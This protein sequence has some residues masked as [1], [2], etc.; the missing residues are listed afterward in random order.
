MNYLGNPQNSFKVFH[1]A[2]TNGKGSVC[3]YINNILLANGKNVGLFTS[4]HL[5][6]INER[7]RINNELI[8]D[9]EFASICLT[10]KNAVDDLVKKG[11]PHP[12]FFEFVFAMCCV[13]FKKK[14]VEYAVIETGLGGRLD[15]TNI[16]QPIVSIITSIGLD[17][18]EYLGDTVDKIAYEKAGIIKSNIPVVYIDSDKVI[19]DVILD[20]AVQL[21]A[22]AYKLRKNDYDILE[23][24]D[25]V[26]DFSINCMYYKCDSL[27]ITLCTSYQVENAMLA[28]TAI[29]ITCADI[30]DSIIR[31]G[32]LLTKWPGRME[33]VLPNI[34]IDGAHNEP[35]IIRFIE[36]VR[37]L[38]KNKKNILMFAV[39]SDKDYTKMI[40]LICNSGLFCKY[41]ITSVG[42]VRATNA[43]MIADI[44]REYT[45]E[46]IVIK[47]HIEDAFGYG[48]D[49]IDRDTYIYC[50]G[51]L[52]LVGSVKKIFGGRN[53]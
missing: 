10:V 39:V 31:R 48:K 5:E 43:S 11:H 24:N 2:G 30:D 28:V 50:V 47:E 37:P 35:A 23:I 12:S 14:A 17:H 21:G 7:F 49:M 44:F 42:G 13:W 36:S 51:S 18:M 33:K 9:L 16:V 22:K 8:S 32:L 6:V 15:A 26:I 38:R 20:K 34:I 41:I 53:D 19:S 4:P 52:Y 46:D 29:K 25:K 40:E 45:S 1:V 3:A 27:Q